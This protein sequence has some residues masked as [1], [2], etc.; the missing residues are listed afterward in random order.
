MARHATFKLSGGHHQT[1]KTI[2]ELLAHALKLAGCP[3][4]GRLSA[5]HV[6]FLGDPGPDLT[7]LGVIDQEIVGLQGH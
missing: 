1:D 3:A 5:L 2:Q 4:C 7:R 6:E